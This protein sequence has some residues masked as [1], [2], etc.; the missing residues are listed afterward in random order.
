FITQARADQAKKSPIVTVGRPSAGGFAAFY[1]E[2]IRQHLEERYGAKRLYESGLAVYTSIDPALQ[3]AAE[4]AFDVGLRKVDKRRGFRKPAHNVIVEGGTPETWSTERWKTP[5]AGGDV[6]PA[7]VIGS[8]H[9]PKSAPPG[10]LML[11]AGALTV[12]V[13]K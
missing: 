2:E 7:V 9:A 3:R 6:V 13:Q 5:M 12:E 10:S 11:R 4:T 1:L 8:S